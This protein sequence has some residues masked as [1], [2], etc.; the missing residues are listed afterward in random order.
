MDTVVNSKFIPQNRLLTIAIGLILGDTSIN[1]ISDKSLDLSYD[2]AIEAID[3]IMQLMLMRPP[4]LTASPLS[5]QNFSRC[6]FKISPAQIPAPRC[7]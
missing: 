3:K 1:A 6:E 4:S 7:Y 2:H 5:V